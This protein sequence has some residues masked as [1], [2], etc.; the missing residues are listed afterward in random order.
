[1]NKSNALKVNPELSG[2]T[3]RSKLDKHAIKIQDN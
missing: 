2:E 1:M 3:N